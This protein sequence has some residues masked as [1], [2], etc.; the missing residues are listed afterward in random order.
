MRQDGYT[1]IQLLISIALM[2]LLLRLA[3]PS[4]QHFVAQQRYAMTAHELASG[5]RSARAEA[6]LQQQVV[7]IQAIDDDWGLGWRMLLDLSGRGAEDPDNPLVVE[8]ALGG[9]V[10]VVG[11][12]RLATRAR[13]IPQGWPAYSG[14]SPGNG[15]LHI[16]EQGVSHWRVVM[17][18]SGRVRMESGAMDEPWCA[19]SSET[20]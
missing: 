12:T 6:I 8:R 9:Q 17:S 10:R 4:W 5:L 1:L 7:L 20:A 14:A 11:N 16:C 15:T 19:Q 3:L 2:G 13:F 18:T